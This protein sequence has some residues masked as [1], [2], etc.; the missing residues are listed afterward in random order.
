M[1]LMVG[2][3]VWNIFMGMFFFFFW[4]YLLFV[5]VDCFFVNGSVVIGIKKLNEMYDIGFISCVGYFSGKVL[6]L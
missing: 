4:G 1:Y 3:L 5:I 2:K 6:Y